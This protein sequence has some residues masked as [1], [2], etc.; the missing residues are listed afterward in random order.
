MKILIALLGLL[1]GAYMLA[2]GIFVMLKGKYIGSDKPGPWA[3]LFNALHI[4]VFKLGPLFIFFG[5][6]WLFFFSA[7]ITQQTWTYPL[8]IVISVLSLWYLP[9]G[10]LFS[11]VILCCLIFARHKVG[12]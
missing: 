6:A 2:D 11:I 1:N 3:N 8:G 12:L 10:T 4:N 5:L 7:L 9:L